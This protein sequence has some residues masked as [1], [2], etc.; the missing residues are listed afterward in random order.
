MTVQGGLVG[1]ARAR[2]SRAP[3][4]SALTGADEPLQSQGKPK[5]FWRLS[6]LCYF[7][8]LW[9]NLIS[10]TGKEQLTGIQSQFALLDSDVEEVIPSVQTEANAEAADGSRDSERGNYMCRAELASDPRLTAL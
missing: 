4:Y 7:F 1:G 9:L 8:P 5:K 6:S 2:P 3:V 10:A